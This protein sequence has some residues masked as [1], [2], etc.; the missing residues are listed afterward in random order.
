MSFLMRCIN[1]RLISLLAKLQGETNL[2]KF[3]YMRKTYNM[4]N[5]SFLYTR[6][7][8]TLTKILK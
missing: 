7:G 3:M 4:R 8:E 6:S 1:E 5:R 2:L